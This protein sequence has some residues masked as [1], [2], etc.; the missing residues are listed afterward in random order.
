M[1]IMYS[2]SMALQSLT[3][4]FL[5]KIL[6]RVLL[7]FGVLLKPSPLGGKFPSHILTNLKVTI[8]YT[9]IRKVFKFFKRFVQIHL[10]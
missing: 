5:N 2:K 9:T 1:S 10:L 4:Y 6:D 3:I 7:G 8:M